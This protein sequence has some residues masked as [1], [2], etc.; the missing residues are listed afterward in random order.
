MTGREQQHISNY[1]NI[2]LLFEDNS[3]GL[4]TNL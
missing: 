4:F 2:F 3:T 1:A